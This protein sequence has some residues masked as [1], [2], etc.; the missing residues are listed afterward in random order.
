MIPILVPTIDFV[1]G[2]TTTIKIMNGILLK[3]FTIISKV[4]YII[5]LG[6]NPS[7]AVRINTTA[8]INPMSTAKNV[9]TKTIINV[10]FIALSNIS[11][12]IL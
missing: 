5:L 6:F 7:G 10:S 4:L 3:T 1:I 11:F 9:E 8:G 2:T 12:H